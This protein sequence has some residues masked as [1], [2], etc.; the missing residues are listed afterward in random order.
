MAIRKAYPDTDAVIKL[1]MLYRLHTLFIETNNPKL[2]KYTKQ[3]ILDTL[4][5]LHKLKRFDSQLSLSDFPKLHR[6]KIKN[7]GKKSVI[8]VNK[9]SECEI[10]NTFFAARKKGKVTKVQVI[11]SNL[12]DNT[13]SKASINV[14]KDNNNENE[15]EQSTQIDNQNEGS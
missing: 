8:D 12:E 1:I 2:S 4:N 15:H 9:E 5:S 6:S 11:S 10:S 13:S 3:Y 14:N 7:Q